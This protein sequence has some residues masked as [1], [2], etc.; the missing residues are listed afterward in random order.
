MIARPDCTFEEDLD[1]T[2]DEDD[3]AMTLD[4][5]DQLEDLDTAD[6]EVL[7]LIREVEA[8]NELT[9]FDEVAPVR[10][11]QPERAPSVPNLPKVRSSAFFQ[12][13]R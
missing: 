5:G 7:A 2:L 8:P 1:D 11:P 13:F 3:E 10:L 12:I 4:D 9:S 6:P